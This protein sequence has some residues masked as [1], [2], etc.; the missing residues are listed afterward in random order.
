[1][2]P[3]GAAAG[4]ARRAASAC[5]ARR[6]SRRACAMI[7]CSISDGSTLSSDAWIRGAGGAPG[8]PRENLAFGRAWLQGL[9]QRDGAAAAGLS[10]RGAVGLLQ[11]A[12][13]GG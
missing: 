6:C 13:C 5:P 10:R 1:P 3:A 12:P 2:P 8:P 7:I 4:A 11:R 9:Q